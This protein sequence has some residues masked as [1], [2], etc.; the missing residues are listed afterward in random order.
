MALE[1]E[2][3]GRRPRLDLKVGFRC[4]NRC[5]FCVQGD[6]RLTVGDRTTEELKAILRDRRE[7]ASGVVFTGGEPTV[8]DDLCDLV[9]HA[10]ELG[11]RPIQV[12]TNGRRLAY[13]PFVRALLA[14]GTTEVSPALHGST[15][16]EQFH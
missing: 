10:H 16:E 4:N 15:E 3:H 7:G 8:R 13:M 11:Y 1:I 9:S 6:K 14:A 12:Q 5:T 2:T